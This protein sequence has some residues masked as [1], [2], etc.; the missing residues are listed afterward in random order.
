[1]LEELKEMVLQANL[2]LPKYGLV[3]FTWGNVSGIDRKSGYIVIKPSGV[4]YEKMCIDD[5]VVVDLNGSVVEGRKRPSSDTPTHVE[6]YKNFPDVGGIV[7]THSRWATAHA[8]AGST[9]PVTGTTH[10][11][12]FYGE[13]PCT[14]MMTSKEIRG[15][16]EKNTGLLIVET[17]NSRNPSKIPGVLV[18]GHGPF[19]WGADAMDAV[20]NSVVLE[21]I[22]FMDCS[23]K[24]LSPNL[25]PIPKEL[26]DKHYL[27]K[28]GINAYYGQ[29]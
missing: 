27:R 15:D 3:T 25:T 7:H 24:L 11:D 28:H 5:M 26:L 18:R 1:M 29:D 4:E 8:Q 14:R 9:I 22:A 23:S 13:I 2:L 6:L 21:D 16:Y 19:T 17:F 12:Y 20:H 10:A